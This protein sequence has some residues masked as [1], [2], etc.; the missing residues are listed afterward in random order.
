MD[1]QPTKLTGRFPLRL[2]EDLDAEI[3]ALARGTSNRPPAGINDT[4]VFLIRKG[5]KALKAEQASGNS[6]PLPIAA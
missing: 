4:I 2:P 1:K 3:R 5:L 6:E